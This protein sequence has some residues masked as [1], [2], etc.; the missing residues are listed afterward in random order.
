[1]SETAGTRRAWA[2]LFD[3][4]LTLADTSY[5]I[6]ECTN[7]LAAK[8]GLR[9]V[10]RKEILSLTGLPI[11][12]TWISL[13]GRWED[14][15]LVYYRSHFSEREH[16]GFLLFPDTR[17]SL[18]KLRE[19]GV[20]TGVVSNRSFVGLAL[21]ACGIKDLFDVVIGREEAVRPK[22]YPDTVLMAIARL[23]VEAGRA[24]YVGDTP[25]DMRAASAAGITGIGVSTGNYD[26]DDLNA[27][28]AVFSCP[29]LARA[30]DMILEQIAKR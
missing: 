14:E 23:S 26:A 13:W 12:E 1:M 9:R 22:P 7:L 28:G 15:W 27:S 18:L 11:E 6:T 25:I 8:Y 21:G 24:F 10:E 29:G 4:D 2:A 17:S 30:A 20:K 5:I 19:N 3:F 16:E